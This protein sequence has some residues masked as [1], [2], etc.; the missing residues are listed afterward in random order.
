MAR[1]RAIR[2][3]LRSFLEAFARR[4]SEPQAYWLFGLLVAD[5][6]DRTIDLLREPEL[7]GP[8]TVLDLTLRQ[9]RALFREQLHKGGLHMLSIRGATLRLRQMPMPRHFERN[10]QPV[11]GYEIQFGITV[12][13]EFGRVFND[14]ESILGAPADPCADLRS[15][16]IR[17][18]GLAP[19]TGRRLNQQG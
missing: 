16:R 5:V 7:A 2:A 11:T 4:Y 17:R 14:T 12:V 1:R 18:S 6:G 10:G 19:R 15:L 13:S 3:V 9:S 8:P